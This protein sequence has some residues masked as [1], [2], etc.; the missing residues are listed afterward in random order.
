MFVK[1]SLLNVLNISTRILVFLCNIALKQFNN[2]G[3]SKTE[4]FIYLRE[5]QTRVSTY[6]S[7]VRSL[8]ESVLSR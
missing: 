3:F 8:E 4:Q 6:C 5:V 1:Q 2:L 7:C